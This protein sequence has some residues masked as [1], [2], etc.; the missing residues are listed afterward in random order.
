MEKMLNM[1]ERV[2][3][4]RA[5]QEFNAALR[6]V[7]LEIP[8]IR[9]TKHNETT[10]SSFADLESMQDIVMPVILRHGFSISYGGG[11][12]LIPDHVRVAITLSHIGGHSRTTHQDG[13]LDMLGMKGNQNKTKIHGMGS[14]V[15][16]LRRYLLMMV[17]NLSLTDE[18]DDGNHGE[19]FTISE[20]EQTK[21]H[22]M[23]AL[24]KRPMDK[25]LTF[26]RVN[27]MAQIP[28]SQYQ[29]AHDTLQ[30]H[31]DELKAE[32]PK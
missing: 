3:K 29:F 7:Q 25:F 14:T 9:K 21:L 23:L 28:A 15:S 2:N 22:E 20:E 16:Y 13:A 24:S 5:E 17:L 26:M 4:S 1:M 18:D 31:I 11:D 10:R 6:A 27:E 19:H 30:R 8:K 12:T 32:E